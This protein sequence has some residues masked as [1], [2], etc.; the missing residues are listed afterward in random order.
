MRL[1]IRS[2]KIV[3][4]FHQM[5]KHILKISQITSGSKKKLLRG[6]QN[7]DNYYFLDDEFPISSNPLLPNNLLF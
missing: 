2:A 4:F 7:D 1:L 6:V 5:L 3:H